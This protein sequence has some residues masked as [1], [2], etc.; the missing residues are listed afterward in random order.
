MTEASKEEIETNIERTHRA[1]VNSETS[2]KRSNI[3]PPYLVANITNWEFSKI[4]KSAFI[5]ESQNGNSRVFVSFK[6]LNA[7]LDEIKHLNTDL[8]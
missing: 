7:Y 2:D 5:V 3:V 6:I 1:Q 4:I 8:N